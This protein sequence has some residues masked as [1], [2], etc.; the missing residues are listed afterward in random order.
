MRTS[1]RPPR[2]RARCF[3]LRFLPVV[4]LALL[5]VAALSGLAHNAAS[6]SA[7]I[8]PCGFE[9]DDSSHETA[10]PSAPGAEPGGD[11]ESAAAKPPPPGFVSILI[12]TDRLSLT[13]YSDEEVWHK[14]TVAT[15][16]SE[17]PTALGEWTVIN[18]GIWSGA[19]GARWMG[20]SIPW[21]TYGIHGTN[22][23]SSIGSRASHGCVRMLNRDV[24]VLYAWVKVGTPVK[25][26][27][28]PRS[29]FG[30]VPREMR[31]GTIG[32][33]VMRL[34]QALR[35]LGLYRN[36]I[37]GRFGWGTERAV[38]D[39]QWATFRKVTGVADKATREAL[40]LP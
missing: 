1:K 3:A 23:P 16:T 25:I 28:R 15:G 17:T 10:N 22:R 38:R 12:D 9:A 13:V 31:N 37:D 4:L 35:E 29:H 26:T 30:E 34:Q 20:L 40:G 5:T 36:R 27:G 33:D 14:F 8:Y 32:S 24:K 18:K 21:A 6:S 39:F 19:F 7:I 2:A 11:A